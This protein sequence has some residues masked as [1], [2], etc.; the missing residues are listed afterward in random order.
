M[1]LVLKLGVHNHPEDLDV[2]LRLNSLSLDCE[3]LRV[4]LVFLKSEVDDRR[5]I[6]FE[7]RSAS[8]LPF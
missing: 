7:S 6:Y 2:V 5:L 3:G 4:C 8:P 1:F